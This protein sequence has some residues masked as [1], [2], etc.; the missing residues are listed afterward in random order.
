MINETHMMTNDILDFNVST[1]NVIYIKNKD[2]FTNGSVELY[3]SLN[4]DDVNVVG[5]IKNKNNQIISN[6]NPLIM[7]L[8]QHSPDCQ[9]KIDVLIAAGANPDYKIM[10]Y[11]KQLSCRDLAKKYFSNINI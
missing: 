9:T 2:I 5:E 4:V 8:N 10:Y 3:K 7:V 11:N 6:I 1:D